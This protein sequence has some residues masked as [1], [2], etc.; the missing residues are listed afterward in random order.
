MLKMPDINYI[1]DLSS[2]GYNITEIAKITCNDP[3][4]IR[5]YLKEEDFSPV[6][7]TVDQKPSIL[8]DFK[9]KV[10]KI[11]E[12]DKHVWFKQRHTAQRI[13][14]RLVEEDGF[15]GS[16]NT[17]Q[18]Y[19]KKVRGIVNTTAKNEL[20]WDAGT[21][22]V[23][24]GEADFNIK[25]HLYRMK[26]LVVSFPYSNNGFCQVFGGETSECVCQGLKNI[27]E[28]IGKVP[29]T[30]IFDNATGVGRRVG[31]TIHE[32]LLFQQFRAHYK[33][34]VKFCNP[35][36]G[37]EKGNVENKVG[38]IRANTFVPVPVI[39]NIDDYNK[40]L[41]DEHIKKA[42]EIHYK[43]G[44][45]ISELFKDDLAAMGSLPTKPFEVCTYKWFNADG[46]GK[47]C[48]DGKH[49]Y[50]TKPENARKKV[51]VGIYANTIRVL[52][53]N[54]AMLVEHERQYGDKRTDLCDYSTSI[55]QLLSTPGSWH[56]S[57]IRQEAP[58]ILRDYMDTL[59][60]K[61]LKSNIKI[62]YDLSQTHDMSTAFKAMALSL[63]QGSINICDAA[64]LADRIEGYGIDTP[65]ETGP[66]LS[67]YDQAFLGVIKDDQ[68]I[69]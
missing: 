15:T 68:C 5:K 17:V 34:V 9:A 18:R 56:N 57:G 13:Y 35:Y 29:H 41:L 7:P 58:N 50:S 40:S 19:V 39:N 66:S 16:Y 24:F 47:V 37:Y 22:Q 12:E 1:R 43:K 64:V 62:L 46:Y 10:D 49:Y 67:V 65:P 31:D 2:T 60:K 32:T 8:D 59:S 69:S 55:S 52:E 54:G 61:E 21:A 4:T 27:F 51:L 33:T 11:L 42:C 53:E 45:L 25:G 44:V 26:Y 38:Y 6:P 63:E 36:A 23:D 28:Y 30:L 20:I 48:L 3:K 14:E